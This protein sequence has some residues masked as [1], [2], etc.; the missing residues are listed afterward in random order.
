MNKNRKSAKINLSVLE[1]AW[2]LGFAVV[3]PLV[4]FILLGRFIDNKLNTSPIFL[5]SGIIL[6]VFISGYG[7]Y[8]SVSKYIE[9]I[10]RGKEEQ[11]KILKK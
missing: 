11:D 8:R 10:E 4:L 5:L 9:K 1:F 3:I 6:S 7:I 2:D